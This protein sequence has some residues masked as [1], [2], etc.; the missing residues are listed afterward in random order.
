[1]DVIVSFIDAITFVLATY[2]VIRGLKRLLN[3]QRTV[4]FVLILFYIIYILPVGIDY[5]I[6][7]PSYETWKQFQGFYVSYNDKLTRVI[8]DVLLLKRWLLVQL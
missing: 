2:W 5:F 6:T 7:Y 3:T 8:Y 1:M 4:Y